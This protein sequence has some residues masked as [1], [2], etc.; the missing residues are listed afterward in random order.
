MATKTSSAELSQRALAKHRKRFL[1]FFPEGFKDQRHIDWEVTYKMIAHDL[2]VELLSEKQ[3]QALLRGRNYG[4]I[5]NR[6]LRVE[7]KTNFLFSFEK[8]AL[9]D[10]V[11][12]REGAKTFSEGLF[13]LLHEGGSLRERFVQWIVSVGELP[14]KKSRVLSWPV[15]TLFPFIAQPTKH[16]IMKPTAMQNAAFELGYDLDY[17]SKPNFHTYERL[18]H[19]SELIKVELADLNPRKHLD[20]QSFLYVIGSAEYERLS[21]EG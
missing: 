12:T 11:K 19:L 15:L 16:I 1:R 14:R 21:S 18:L 2:W 4:E 6:A 17:S 9:R 8:M 5:V 7:A 10:G 3:Y 13:Q 20:T